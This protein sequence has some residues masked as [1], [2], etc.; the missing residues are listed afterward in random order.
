MIYSL[1]P[2]SVLIINL[3][4]NWES[5]RKYGFIEKNLDV[6]KRI[7][8]RYNHFVL[9]ATL[10]FIVDMTWGLLYEHKEISALFKLF[11]EN[12]ISFP[13]IPLFTHLP[14]Y[15]SFLCY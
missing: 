1:V 14:S 5:L 12:L 4:I 15:I 6:K 10:Y 9:A 8:V 3:I 2:A 11:K 7:P 13:E